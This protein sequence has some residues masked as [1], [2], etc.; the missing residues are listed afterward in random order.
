M[1]E[2]W[3]AVYTERYMIVWSD[4][5]ISYNY[6][7]LVLNLFCSYY[8]FMLV[9][10][11]AR[12]KPCLYEGSV[13]PDTSFKLSCTVFRNY[14]ATKERL[15]IM[16]TQS[17][18][19]NVWYA[20]YWNDLGVCLGDS[21]NMCYT[22]KPPMHLQ[23]T[24]NSPVAQTKTKLGVSRL[25]DCHWLQKSKVMVSI[26]S[27]MLAKLPQKPDDKHYGAKSNNTKIFYTN[28]SSFQRQTNLNQS[29]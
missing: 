11:N 18:S 6:N 28:T 4:D 22:E 16:F 10:F 2:W 9:M 13:I 24:S 29:P 15:L 23:I 17:Y 14:F 7:I 20:L 27:H 21:P 5:I 12:T 8:L 26:S 3:Y 25:T 19:G 1:T